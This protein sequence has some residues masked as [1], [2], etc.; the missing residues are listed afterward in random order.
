MLSPFFSRR[1]G[2]VEASFFPRLLTYLYGRKMADAT[3]L[4]ADSR[5]SLLVYFLRND[6]SAAKGGSSYQKEARFSLSCSLISSPRLLLW[7]SPVNTAIAPRL[8]PLC[9]LLGKYLQ[10]R[11]ILFLA[12]HIRVDHVVQVLVLPVGHCHCGLLDRS[13]LW[14]T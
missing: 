5:P 12:E 7:S 8:R 4:L 11:G 6:K 9:L 3:L 10:T 14:L 2:R 13:F 1:Q